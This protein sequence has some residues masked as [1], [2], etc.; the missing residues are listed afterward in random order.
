MQITESSVDQFYLVKL[1]SVNMFVMWDSLNSLMNKNN[2][3][4]K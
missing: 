2:F 1:K 4:Y 3:I